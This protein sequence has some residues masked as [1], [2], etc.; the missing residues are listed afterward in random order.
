[1][2]NFFNF[3]KYM[4]KTHCKLNY[5]IVLFRQKMLLLRHLHE[6]VDIEVLH[7]LRPNEYFAAN[8]A[9]MSMTDLLT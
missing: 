2:V 6:P 1:M 4:P 5:L 9:Y 8:S 3:D 7:F